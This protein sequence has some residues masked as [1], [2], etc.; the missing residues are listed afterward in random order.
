MEALLHTSDL[1]PNADKPRTYYFS[2]QMSRTLSLLIALLPDPDILL[3]DSLDAKLSFPAQQQIWQ[4]IQDM[5]AQRPRLIF[6]A[7]DNV[8]TAQALADKVWWVE[9]GLL[10]HR[11]VPQAFAA[12][13]ETQA[14]FRLE[15]KTP[16][17]AQ[18]YQTDVSA[19]PFVKS[20]AL[21][22]NRF[23]DV[24][25][26]KEENLVDLTITAGVSLAGFQRLPVEGAKL[27]LP[28]DTPADAPYKWAQVWD[29]LLPPHKPRVRSRSPTL[30]VKA[31]MWIARAEWQ[32]HF[33]NFWK[34]GNLLFSSIWMLGLLLLVSE[35]GAQLPEKMLLITGYVLVAAAS[36]GLPMSAGMIG[37]YLYAANGDTLF[38]D[39]EPPDSSQ[40]L[41]LLSLY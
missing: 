13:L 37:R 32:R 1:L 8:Q 10:Q 5:Q 7:T 27:I 3:I 26:Q 22:D 39:A 33:R 38:D 2:P 4:A 34:A 12:A 31:I 15:M 41:T 14:G 6:C 28:L 17:L 18:K 29:E 21:Q 16:T 40:P 24:F 35:G 9:N 23:V 30:Q 19:L 20:T 11:W 36:F 25:V